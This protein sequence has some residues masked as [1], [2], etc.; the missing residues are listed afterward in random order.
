M[1][2]SEFF[3]LVGVLV[4]GLGIVMFFRQ[5]AQMAQAAIA[6]GI[7]TD[8]IPV[9]AE[10]EYVVSKGEEG[11]KIERKYR[12]R[13]EIRFKTHAGRTID[14]IAPIATRP[15]RY[16]I[17]DPVEVIYD[18]EKPQTAQIN[19]FLYLWFFTLMLVGFG[20]FF[21]GMGVLGV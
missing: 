3:I 13:P 10:G 17:G 19:S 8:L 14:F 4:I 18:P 2:I 1:S 15:S 7:V 16:A 9:R 6:I 12:Y 20:L 21:V 5:R 11:T